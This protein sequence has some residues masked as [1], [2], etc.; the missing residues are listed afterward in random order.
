MFKASAIMA[1]NYSSSSSGDLST[2]L[3][4]DILQ[5]RG[6]SHVN[7]TQLNHTEIS[8]EN[9]ST[10]NNPL[11][12]LTQHIES[13]EHPTLNTSH[14]IN[15]S[16]SSE[17]N[18]SRPNEIPDQESRW[19]INRWKTPPNF[20]WS[21]RAI[22]AEMNKPLTLDWVKA[23][24]SYVTDSA[25]TRFPIALVTS[26]FDYRAALLNWLILS[27]VQLQDPI[28]NVLV[29]SLDTE[30]DDLLTMRNISSIYVPQMATI[31]KNRFLNIRRVEVARLFAMRLLTHWGHS[32]VNY[33][34]DALLL[35]NPQPLFD[36][37]PNSQVIAGAGS[38]PRNLNEKWGFVLCM[39]AVLFRPSEQT[40]TQSHVRTW[41]III[42]CV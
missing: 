38:M 25:D 15:S 27:L 29:L 22:K 40:G 41:L 36:R 11:R 42:Q 26:N 7:S 30:L 10:K 6:T 32:V 16:N 20:P 1:E 39:G 3:P 28:K 21:Q 8:S 4:V 19:A 14:L 35:R 23:L 12:S 18:V 37:H 5:G 31:V 33:D 17:A 34:C 9:I 24:K 13:R 2:H